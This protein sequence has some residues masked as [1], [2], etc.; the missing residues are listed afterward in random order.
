MDNSPLTLCNS[1]K[2][3]PAQILP[4]ILAPSP[5][6]LAQPIENRQA[7]YIDEITRISRAE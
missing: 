6:L 5:M 4:Q 3:Q 1:P 2:I 7:V